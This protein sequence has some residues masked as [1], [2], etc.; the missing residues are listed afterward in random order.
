MLALHMVVK[1]PWFPSCYFI[2]NGSSGNSKNVHNIVHLYINISD[3]K[4]NGGDLVS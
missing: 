2:G 4:C 3:D 1:W